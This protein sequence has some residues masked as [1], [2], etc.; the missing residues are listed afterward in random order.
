MNIFRVSMLALISIVIGVQVFT[1]TKVVDLEN[2]IVS[3]GSGSTT[4]VKAINAKI[5][6]LGSSM[7]HIDQSVLNLSTRIDELIIGSRNSIQVSPTPTLTT[8]MPSIYPLPTTQ[9]ILDPID[10]PVAAKPVIYLYPTTDQS[11]TVRL[12]TNNNVYVT[13]PRAVV[14]NHSY[15]WAT[16][17]KPSGEIVYGGESFN[18]LFWES[19]TY[20]NAFSFDAD[21]AYLVR[22]DDAETFLNET[23]TDIGLQKKERDEMI[24]YWLPY[25]KKNAFSLVYFAGKEYSDMFMLQITPQPESLLRVFMVVKPVHSYMV[26]H[27]KPMPTFQR[28]GFTVVEWGGTYIEN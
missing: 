3:V 12:I 18:Y 9:E 1:I 21:K 22:K 27:P 17:V 16:F 24:V 7:M 28:K 25:L 23:L 19:E 26:T 2:K 8:Q 6:S 10:F 14:R 15:E 11:V 13:Y 4:D 5:D 20:E